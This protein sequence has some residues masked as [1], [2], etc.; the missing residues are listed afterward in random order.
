MS[1]RDSGGGEGGQLM[2]QSCV[3]VV[4]VPFGWI[5]LSMFVVGQVLI[6]QALTTTEYLIATESRKLYVIKNLRA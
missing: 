3:W 6:T 5:I 2:V 1:I 4:V